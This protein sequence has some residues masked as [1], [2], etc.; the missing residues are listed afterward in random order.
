MI[1][2]CRR[3]RALPKVTRLKPGGAFPPRCSSCSVYFCANRTPAYC[4][5]RQTEVLALQFRLT[6]LL[7][8][9]VVFS[10]GV[11]VT[12]MFGSRACLMAVGSPPPNLF[13]WWVQPSMFF[14][15][16]QPFR[17]PKTRREGGG[18]PNHVWS[19]TSFF[20]GLPGLDPLQPPKGT[21]MKLL[22]NAPVGSPSHQRST[23]LPVALPFILCRPTEGMHRN[24]WLNEILFPGRTVTVVKKHT[25]V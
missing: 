7:N 15:Q 23:D 9:Q 13:G 25:F 1:H 20:F 21:G 3:Q 22:I 6:Y 12:V 11:T 16:P 19:T 10:R 4:S 24:F 2:G 8:P 14:S 18:F 17:I 5:A